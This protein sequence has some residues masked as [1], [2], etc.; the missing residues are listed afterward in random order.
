[1]S[2]ST[3]SHYILMVDDLAPQTRSS[4]LKSEFGRHGP[5]LSVERDARYRCALVEFKSSRD[6]QEAWER[7]EGFRFDGRRLRVDWATRKDLDFFGWKWTESTPSPKR[8]RGRSRSRS[9]SPSP[10]RS[11]SR[12]SRWRS[13]SLSDRKTESKDEKADIAP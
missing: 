9:A 1:M 6:A 7:M 2:R 8:G 4:D 11:P 12:D 5:I 13:D 10:S 3:K